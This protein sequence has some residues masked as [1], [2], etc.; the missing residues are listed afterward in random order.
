[1]FSVSGFR[2]SEFGKKSIPGR[3]EKIV[4]LMHLLT[5]ICT[6][7]DFICKLLTIKE[8]D[9]KEICIKT[10]RIIFLGLKVTNFHKISKNQ[11]ISLNYVGNKT[12]SF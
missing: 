10:M 2:I 9:T 4:I 5:L 8:H 7:L 1:M 6:N 3:R 12:I 11:Q